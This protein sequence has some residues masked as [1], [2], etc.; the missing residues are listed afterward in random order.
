[1]G[2]H[3]AGRDVESLLAAL[4]G[5]VRRSRATPTGAVVTGIA[6]RAEDVEPGSLFVAMKGTSADG[7]SFIADA[8]RRGAVAAVV[9]R[10]VGGALDLPLIRVEDGR[11]ALAELAAAWHGH[12]ADR[13]Q[14]AGITGT[15]GKTSTLALLE[16]ILVTAGA[17]VATIGSLGLRVAGRSL[18]ETVYTTPDPLILQA[19]LAR[20]VRAGAR[21]AAME[22]T[23]HA[24]VQRRVHELRY[25]LGIFTNLLPLEHEDYHGSF[26]GYIEAKSLFFDLLEP[27]A[28]LI[29]N[30]DDPVTCRLLEERELVSVP[31]GRSKRAAVRVRVG[32]MDA[33]GTRLCLEAPEPIPAIDGG[34][35]GP[36]RLDLELRLLGRGNVAN[37]ALAATAALCLGADP[38]VIPGA[39]AA[40]APPR[41]RM[42]VL[43]AGD[44]TLLDDTVGHPESVNALFEVV[45]ALE[46][47]GVHIV[48]AVRGRRG[49]RINR[50][51]AEALAVWAGRLRLE[52]LLVT[53]AAES[54]DALNRVEAEEYAAF[55]EPLRRHGVRH[56]ERPELAP[57]VRDALEAAGGGDLVLLLGAQGMDRGREVAEE[58]L[59]ATSPSGPRSAGG[60]A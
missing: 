9:E 4:T 10:D 17:P 26:E 31:V 36:V 58:W 42:E 11:R 20:V 50:E 1:M 29:Y 35:V 43:Y 51:N 25:G 48:W 38:A 55:L 8:A 49:T 39:L 59:A 33:T 56:E 45:E 15:A 30:V 47:A 54:A 12:P 32:D 34:R 41:R 24:L 27:G 2:E 5:P 21:I 6:A 22:V 60:R 57:A 3:A 44:F 13:L 19:E 18:E 40:V 28:P 46:P 7:H 53:A 16:T 52:T 37:A 14:L 23:S